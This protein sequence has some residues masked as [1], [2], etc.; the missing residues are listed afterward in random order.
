ME[1]IRSLRVFEMSVARKILGCSKRDHKRNT[2]ILNE[3][4]IKKDIVEIPRT[5]RLSYF[6]HFARMNPN[7]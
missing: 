3:L 7:K 5:R 4:S 2:D 6:G 1:N